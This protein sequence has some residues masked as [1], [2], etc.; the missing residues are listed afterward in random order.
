[1]TASTSLPRYAHRRGTRGFAAFV[2]SIAGFVVLGVGA[3]VLPTVALDSIAASWLIPL[4]VAFGLAHFVAAYGLIRRRDWGGRLVGYLAAIGIG[5]AAYGLILTLTGMDPFGATSKLPS[6]RAWAEGLGLLIWMIGLWLVAA[7]Y[8]FK[9]IR[10]IE[11]NAA[12]IT[13][14]TMAAAAA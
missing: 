5:I 8:A 3:V 10:P 7:R 6:D 11:P 4:T 12:A 2:T 13:P 9:A 1:L 14:L